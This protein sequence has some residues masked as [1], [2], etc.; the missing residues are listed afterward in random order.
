MMQCLRD[1]KEKVN[2]KHKPPPSLPADQQ[3]LYGLNEFCSLKKFYLW[4][5]VF[6]LNK[7]LLKSAM[8]Q[9]LFQA[10]VTQE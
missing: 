10:L 6:I 4:K 7:H 9:I 3:R 8:E 1:L 2:L 5:S